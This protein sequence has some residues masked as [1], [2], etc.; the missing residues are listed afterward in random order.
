MD[1]VTAGR[2][3]AA[4]LLRLAGLP[5]ASWLAGAAPGLMALVTDVD[6]LADAYQRHSDQVVADIGGRLIGHPALLAAQWPDV[7]HL[8]RALRNGWAPPPAASS[9]ADSAELVLPD[10]DPLP[11]RIR[12]LVKAA[13]ELAALRESAD[14]AVAAEERRLLAAPWQLLHDSASGRHAVRANGMHRDTAARVAAGEPWTTRRMRQRAESLWRLIDHGGTRA[15]P[16]GW[17][18]QVALVPVVPDGWTGDRLLIQDRAA[19][20]CTDSDQVRRTGWSTVERVP[21]NNV[22]VYRRSATGVAESHATRLAELVHLGLRALVLASGTVAAPALPAQ[23]GPRPRLLPNL[24]TERW[25]PVAPAPGPG[26]L[27]RWIGEHA[28]GADS[29]DVDIDTLDRL[30]APTPAVDWPV[31]CLLR[32][33]RAHDGPVA[34]LDRICPAGVLDARFA[35]AMRDLYPRVPQADEY[36]RFLCEIGAR[37]GIPVV[38]VLVPPTTAP[39]YSSW[40]TG[41]PARAGQPGIYVSPARITLRTDAGQVIAEVDGRR[42]WPV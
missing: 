9:V 27:D 21:A 33:I 10:G 11:V 39:T 2:D 3:C 24:A 23:L 20:E 41:D 38:E 36:R 35:S 42:I 26:P 37:A 32:P 6:R 7:L 40:W 14:H 12:T 8:R 30:G 29:I 31:D 19:A 4:V 5:I 15:T 13:A 17:L 18:G 25:V 16:D 34:V 28:D 22:D 1:D